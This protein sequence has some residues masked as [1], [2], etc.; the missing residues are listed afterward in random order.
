MLAALVRFSRWPTPGAIILGNQS[1]DPAVMYVASASFLHGLMP[2]RDFVFLHPPG[3][4]LGM[5]PS[6]LVGSIFGDAVGLASARVGVI[7]LGVG[8]ATLVAT[9][10]SRYGTP[11]MLLGGGLYAGWGALS[12]TEQEPLL[13]PFLITALLVSLHLFRSRSQWAPL[14]MGMILGIATMVKVW[15]AVDLV[16]FAVVFLILRRFRDFGRFTLGA[17]IGGSAVA[18]PFFASAPALM[19]EM[20]V[21]AQL[22]RPSGEVSLMARANAFGPVPSIGHPAYKVMVALLLIALLAVSVL[23]VFRGWSRRADSAEAIEAAIWAGIALVHTFVILVSSSFYSHYAMF[24]AAPLTL[25]AGATLGWALERV[26]LNP[27][28]VTAAVTAVVLLVAAFSS[29]LSLLRASRTTHTS[30]EERDRMVAWA[31]GFGCTWSSVQ[32]RVL[33]DEVVDALREGCTMIVDPFGENLLAYSRGQANWRDAGRESE[34]SQLT[35]ADGL[36]LPADEA[37]WAF[38]EP[39]ASQVRSNFVA[40]EHV[41]DRVLWVR[42]TGGD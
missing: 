21:T 8:N 3:V 40:S 36:V 35:Q 6:V 33:I 28:R 38:A 15:T 18:L 41:G 13:E 20:V 12:Y 16:M 9:L 32:D 4:L 11:C 39:H 7:L 22:G 19:W 17:A 25:V 37:L 2:Y 31:D 29:A 10:L 1:Y 30:L 24:F 26:D 23:L 5:A 42:Q 14:W 27:R 34:V